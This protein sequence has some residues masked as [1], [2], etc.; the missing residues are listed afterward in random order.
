MS[1]A[2]KL[3]LKALTARQLFGWRIVKMGIGQFA[4]INSKVA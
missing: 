2:K 4:T 1:T 3:R